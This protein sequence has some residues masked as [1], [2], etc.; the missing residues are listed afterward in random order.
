MYNLNENFSGSRREPH[1]R[2]M[3][4]Q[5]RANG[6]CLLHRSVGRLL[7]ELGRHCEGGLT[8]GLLCAKDLPDRQTKMDSIYMG[9]TFKLFR[10]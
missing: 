10:R 6:L 1:R 5:E 2:C 9:K 3:Y 4:I 8:N 7:V